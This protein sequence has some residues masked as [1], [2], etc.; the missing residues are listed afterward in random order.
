MDIVV[1]LLG[2]RHQERWHPNLVRTA[3]H[4]DQALV[5]HRVT[6]NEALRADRQEKTKKR[7]ARK[8]RHLNAHV[9]IDKLTTKAGCF[10]MQ[11]TSEGWGY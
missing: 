8:Q 1:H 6:L 9:S 3:E 4:K 10:S 2:S 5:K 11:A 7:R